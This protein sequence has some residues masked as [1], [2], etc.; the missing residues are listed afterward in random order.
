[1]RGLIALA[2]M[3]ALTGAPAAAELEWV[4]S[5]GGR[6]TR[7]AEG[8]ITG[9]NLRGRWVTDTDMRELAQLPHLTH[10]DLSLT[11]VTD[12]GLLELKNAPGIVELNLHYA[13]LVTDEGVSAVKGWKKLK[14]LSVRGARISDTTLEHVSGVTTLESLDVGSALVTDV[15]LERLTTLPNLR[16]LSIGGNEMGD[17]GLQALRQMPALRVLDLSGAQGTDS[18]IWSVNMTEKG[19]DAVLSL[20]EL[21]ELRIACTGIGV[22]VEGTRFAT[23]TN[24]N[25]TARWIER[26]KTLTK[27]EK[28]RLQGCGRVDDDAIPALAA[29]PALRE[30]DLK[31]TSVTA[32]GVQMLRA[33]K[34]KAVVHS[35]EWVARTASF[36]NN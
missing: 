4:S 17:A 13:E 30:L 16:E 24:M 20:K 31:G 36:R 27:L 14:R 26:M 28:L 9:V 25:V 29:M 22:G 34:P 32:K 11:R 19:L 8:R 3:V 21:R 2:G 6:I 5:V 35:G 1:M 15:G 33:A 12:Q 10:L 18:N 23:V 7:D